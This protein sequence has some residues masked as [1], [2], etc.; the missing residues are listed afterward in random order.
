VGELGSTAAEVEATMYCSFNTSCC[1][2]HQSHSRYT[3]DKVE[4]NQY[5]YH[6]IVVRVAHIIGQ[7]LDELEQVYDKR[8]V[9]LQQVLGAQVLNTRHLV[10]QLQ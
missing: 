4:T 9:N 2:N 3:Q 7:S 8:I 1:Y 6:G 5:S 10:H